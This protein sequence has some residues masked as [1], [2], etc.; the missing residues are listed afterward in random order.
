MKV[1]FKTKIGTKTKTGTI[2]TLSHNGYGFISQDSGESNTFFHVS[3]LSGSK[4]DE[5]YE[6]MKVE[7]LK[8]KSKKGVQAI[9]VT[10]IN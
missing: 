10:V 3:D 4:F 2:Q 1:G 6:G 9:K 5:L 8:A 7:Y